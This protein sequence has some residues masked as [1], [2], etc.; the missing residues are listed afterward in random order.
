MQKSRVVPQRR[1][2]TPSPQKI[3]GHP[4]QNPVAEPLSPARSDGDGL[5]AGFF[6]DPVVPQPVQRKQE[7]LP[8][9]L[10]TRPNR[11]GLPDTLKGGIESLS[12]MSMDHV[13]VHY[14]SAKPAQL[15]ASAYTRGNEIHV[16]PGQEQHLPH[17]AWHVVQQAEGRVKPTM[18][19]AGL[20]INDDHGLEREADVMG[21]KALRSG[22]RALTQSLR[23]GAPDAEDAPVQGVFK[24]LQ[25]MLKGT[26]KFKNILPKVDPI[27]MA[28]YK[29]NFFAGIGDGLTGVDN[30]PLQADYEFR[31]F[32]MKEY[33]H[34]NID[35]E[36]YKK[37]LE[38]N[39]L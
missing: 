2:R 37:L 21:N 26:S 19:M 35:K 3:D 34:G 27:K 39:D 7:D 1:N 20:P 32:L 36:T 31:V 22:G 9:P 28:N 15:Q 24:W 10:E 12:G 29:A 8:A 23:C 5:F 30:D 33:E 6:S 25:T 16:A 38:D 11:T 14:N 18:Q 4:S 17:E 13:R